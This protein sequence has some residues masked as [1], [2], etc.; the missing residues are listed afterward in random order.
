MINEQY[1]KVNRE[2]ARHIVKKWAGHSTSDMTENVYT[3][4]NSDFEKLES[5]KLNKGVNDTYSQEKIG[6]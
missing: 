3:H 5:Q 1:K 4:T 2:H 6:H